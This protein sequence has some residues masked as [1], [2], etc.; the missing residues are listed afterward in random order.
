MAGSASG[1]FG[2][3]HSTGG[4][5]LLS[6]VGRHDL[7]SS[8]WQVET[9][10]EGDDREEKSRWRIQVENP[11]G[12]SRWRIQVENPG[13]EETREEVRSGGGDKH[14]SPSPMQASHSVGVVSHSVGVVVPL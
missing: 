8:R 3:R 14:V 6:L 2:R 13:G 5:S 9:R 7:L 1:V 4:S 11:G 10:Q 12:E